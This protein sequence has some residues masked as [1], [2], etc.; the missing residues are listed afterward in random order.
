VDEVRARWRG[1]LREGEIINA[2]LTRA[3]YPCRA[4]PPGRT[5]PNTEL[6]LTEGM[7]A[8][9]GVGAGA[10]CCASS[11]GGDEN[12]AQLQPGEQHYQPNPEAQGLAHMWFEQTG[13][14]EEEI[15]T[16]SFTGSI[17]DAS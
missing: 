15:C 12:W 17:E 1:V 3:T 5:N 14:S 10:A 9:A 16:E 13:I 11:L 2:E 8:G 7:G 6:G 4:L